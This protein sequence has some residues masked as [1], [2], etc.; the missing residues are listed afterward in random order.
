MVMLLHKESLYIARAVE[1]VLNQAFGNFEWININDASTNNRFEE[2]E[3][4]S[5][6]RVWVLHRDTSV[7]VCVIVDC[8]RRI[9]HCILRELFS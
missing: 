7:D 4:F 3:E 9:Y 1:S 2:I 6:H 5:D 8:Y